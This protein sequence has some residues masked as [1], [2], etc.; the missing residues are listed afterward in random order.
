MGFKSIAPT[1]LIAAPPLPDPN[2]ARTVV[3]LFHHTPEGALGLVVNRPTGRKVGE[4]LDAI[5]MTTKNEEIRNQPIL[6]G[7]PVAPLS[8]W[9]I[10]EAKGEQKESFK[11]LDDL[12]VSGSPNVLR[13]VLSKDEKVPILFLLGYAGWG[14]GQLEGEL[15]GGVWLPAEIDKK[16]LFEI[17]YEDRWRRRLIALGVDPA[18]WSLGVGEG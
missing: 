18:M 2:F 16:T 4:L 12:W 14:P 7:G 1:F 13:E 8:A 11:V 15:D 9:L 17:P 5:E 3:M 10:F 6:L